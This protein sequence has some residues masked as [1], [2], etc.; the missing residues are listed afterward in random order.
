VQSQPFRKVRYKRVKKARK[1]GATVGA[2]LL[3]G[4]CGC[5]RTLAHAWVGRKENKECEVENRSGDSNQ[6]IR[7]ETIKDQK[8]TP[9]NRETEK[10]RMERS[11]Q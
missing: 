4:A 2:R 10:K 3:R 7:E 9:R 1:K 11:V 8:P 6:I 5:W